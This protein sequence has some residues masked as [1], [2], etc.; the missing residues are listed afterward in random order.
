M[1]YGRCV[2]AIARWRA[3]G[4]ERR[5]LSRE[6]ESYALAEREHFHRASV[7]EFDTVAERSDLYERIVARLRD[8]DR[9]L[10]EGPLRRLEVILSEPPPVR[11]YG[12]NAVRRNERIASVLAELEGD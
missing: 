7:V 3:P 11:D 2:L 5:R 6:V 12:L 8:F 1:A 10:P 9:P 4:R